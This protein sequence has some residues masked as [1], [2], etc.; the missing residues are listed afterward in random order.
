VYLTG[1]PET[2]NI[3]AKWGNGSNEQCKGSYTLAGSNAS[4][5][6]ALIKQITAQ[7]H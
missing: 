7:C 5:P 1:L 6:S 4:D 2:G 3:M